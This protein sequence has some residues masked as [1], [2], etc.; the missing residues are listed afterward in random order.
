LP[1]TLRTELG[2][3]EKVITSLAHRRCLS[4]DEQEDFSSWAR[5]RL[6]ERGDAIFERFQGQSTLS[7]YLTTVVHNLFRDYR[8]A[9][10]GKFRPS[11]TAKRMGTVAVR[12]EMLV[13]RDGLPLD[14]AVEI[15]RRNEGVRESAEELE[16]MAARLPVRAPRRFEGEETLAHLPGGE[17]AE[18]RVLR[19]EAAEAAGRVE[20]A[21]DEG[22]RTLSPEDRLILKMKVHDGFSVADI[23]RSLHLDQKPLYRRL[24]QLTT[25][26]CQVMEARGVRREDVDQVVEWEEAEIRVDYHLDDETPE[27]RPSKQEGGP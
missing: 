16:A 22:L 12:L 10:W 18:E 6:V 15:L 3:C 11:A 7:T 23:A 13:A 25:R 8:I 14:E 4:L 19:R 24:E 21:L 2:L 26:L 9:K 27:S 5:L 17:R 20:A 1:K